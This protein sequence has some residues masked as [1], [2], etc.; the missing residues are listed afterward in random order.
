MPE[1]IIFKK[2]SRALAFL[3]LPLHGQFSVTVVRII[4]TSFLMMTCVIL[5][6][7]D[8]DSLLDL[9]EYREL[10]KQRY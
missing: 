3:I 9:V 2:M 6:L 4:I 7:S 5:L 10:P 8:E 1:F